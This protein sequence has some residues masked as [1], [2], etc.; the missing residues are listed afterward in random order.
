LFRSARALALLRDRD[1]VIP[2]DIKALA[3]PVIAHRLVLSP[4]ARMRG[5]RNID[6]VEDLLNNVPVPG[7]SR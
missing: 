4:S 1:Y 5:M 7:A 3:I 6:V 2:D